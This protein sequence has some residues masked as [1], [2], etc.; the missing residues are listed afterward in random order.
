MPSSCGR[1]GRKKLPQ[2][3]N[4]PCTETIKLMNHHPAVRRKARA[5]G[6]CT[7]IYWNFG[8]LWQCCDPMRE[9]P[10]IGNQSALTPW[11][12]EKSTPHFFTQLR[13]PALMWGCINKPLYPRKSKSI[14]AHT[15]VR[16]EVY[17]SR[18][19][20]TLGD[21]KTGKYTIIYI[22]RTD[23]G[24]ESGLTSFLSQDHVKSDPTPLEWE[25]ATVR[26]SYY[27]KWYP[28]RG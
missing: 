17:T 26:H 14:E 21:R 11:R 10:T 18:N 12:P 19:N 20:I 24:L 1:L 25:D 3:R 13:P 7:G 16:R 6:L 23:S 28:F 15:F 5:G 22:C 4:L 9:I 27:M 8:G 2:H